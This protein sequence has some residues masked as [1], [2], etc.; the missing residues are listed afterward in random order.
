M[1]KLTFCSIKVL[2]AVSLMLMHVNV[3]SMV[4]KMDPRSEV[5]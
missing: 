1:E 2:D 4:C 3:R 5:C